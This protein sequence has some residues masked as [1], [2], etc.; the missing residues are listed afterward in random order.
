[1][2]VSEFPFFFWG[3]VGFL[4]IFL[5]H[6]IHLLSCWWSLGW[7]QSLWLI[8]YDPGCTRMCVGLYACALLGFKL[9]ALCLLRWCS[10]TWATPPVFLLLVCLSDTVL[11]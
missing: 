4:C 6:F 2:Q 7:F 11:N 3:W 10:T 1:M 9:W 5:P 8:C